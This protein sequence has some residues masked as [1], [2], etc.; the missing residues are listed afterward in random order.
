MV[1]RVLD[2][3]IIAHDNMIA[4]PTSALDGL[5]LR[6]CKSRKGDILSATLALCEC[7]CTQVQEC[8]YLRGR[9]VSSRKYKENSVHEP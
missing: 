1:C 8:N 3:K 4:V 5:P 7:N 2:Q 6:L 9:H